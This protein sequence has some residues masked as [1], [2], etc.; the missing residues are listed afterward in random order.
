MWSL[1]PKE[2]VNIIIQYDGRIK[3]RRGKYVNQLNIEN[4]KYDLL[5]KFFINK[6]HIFNKIL[7][8]NG[9]AFYMDFPVGKYYFGMI[10]DYKYHGSG[11]MVS[12]YKNIQESLC[13]I[14]IDIF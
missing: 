12:F 13:Y 3:Y 8:V 5:N 1:L 11:Y 9:D 2:I 6:T 7:F 4:K 10:Y 14:F